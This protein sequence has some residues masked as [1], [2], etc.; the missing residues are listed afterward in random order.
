MCG[1]SWESPGSVVFLVLVLPSPRAVSSCSLP[2]HSAIRPSSPWVPQF[3]LI[4]AIFLSFHSP[5][6]F[7]P[8]W[9]F[10]HT[11]LLPTVDPILFGDPTICPVLLHSSRPSLPFFSTPFSLHAFLNP[12]H[13]EFLC[14]ILLFSSSPVFLLGH[15]L[16]VPSTLVLSF[17]CLDSAVLLSPGR[18]FSVVLPLCSFL[19]A[20][21]R[22]FVTRVSLCLF[23]LFFLWF[24]SCLSRVSRKKCPKLVILGVPVCRKLRNPN[25]TADLGT[26]ARAQSRLKDCYFGCTPRNARSLSQYTDAPRPVCENERSA[27]TH[28]RQSR[29]APSPLTDSPPVLDNS[30]VTKHTHCGVHRDTDRLEV[31]RGT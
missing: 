27:D 26:H 21:S 24:I 19:C 7:S 8:R 31:G 14:S 20:V 30:F 13:F 9:K 3:C 28:V 11:C 25:T 18:P 2:L 23:V 6:C 15:I 16:P 1:L 5:F 12:F 22:F 17:S 10:S 4:T 29:S